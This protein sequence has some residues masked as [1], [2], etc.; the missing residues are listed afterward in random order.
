MPL[1]LLCYF[2]AALIKKQVDTVHKKA[3]VNT[4]TAVCCEV[5]GYIIPLSVHALQL[6]ALHALFFPVQL[7]DV[8]GWFGCYLTSV[9]K[10]Y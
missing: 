9:E 1:R 3:L 10:R 6:I 8:A 2:D 4:L 7:F 5:K